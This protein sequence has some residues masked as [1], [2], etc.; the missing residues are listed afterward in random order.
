MI[1]RMPSYYK[2]FKCIADKCT[3]N[4]CIG[5]EIDID[6]D[7]MEF[8]RNVKGEFGN[9]LNEGISKTEVPHFIL[10]KE[11]RCYFLNKN[12]LCEIFINLGKGSLCEICSEHPRYYEWYKNVKEGGIGLCCEAAARI[13]LNDNNTFSYY[14]TPIDFDC[15]G[16]YDK[17]FY[18]YLFKIR[19]KMIVHMNRQDI[20]LKKRLNNILQYAYLL[21]DKYDNFNYEIIEIENKAIK[22]GNYDLTGI[23]RLFSVLE[24]ME[25][26][27]IF[28]EM[29]H[30]HENLASSVN[31][32]KNNL[33]LNKYLENAAVY[34]IWRH[35][36]KS[37][38]EDEFFSKIAFAVLSVIILKLLFLCDYKKNNILS[39]N[40]CVRMAVYYS[41][42]IE[43]SEE[44]L[45]RIFDSFYNNESFSINN[46]EK[47]LAI[48]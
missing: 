6:K 37:V 5:W 30:D 35:F 29:I 22:S 42:E 46:I 12:R 44:N 43:Y 48:I 45:N 26:N 4:C 27:S 1:L 47:L 14:D 20:P 17:D 36:L 39:E 10:D 38:Y 25:N 7:S 8:Y 28:N 21:Q 24:A 23:L 34:F 13:I 15:Y 18:D 40:E 16:E 2:N 19:E 9:I 31:F 11:R 3:D 32:L 41:K 33:K